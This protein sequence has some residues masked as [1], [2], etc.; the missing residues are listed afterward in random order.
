MAVHYVRNNKCVRAHIG[1]VRNVQIG[2]FARGYL[3]GQGA[4]RRAMYRLHVSGALAKADI[5][6]KLSRATGKWR[7]TTVRLNPDSTGSIHCPTKQESNLNRSQIGYP[8]L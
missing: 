7:I 5:Q 6:V 4:T 1:T 2:Y 8:R 3:K